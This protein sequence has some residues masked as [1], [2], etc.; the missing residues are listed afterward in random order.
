M[1]MVTVNGAPVDTDDPCALY[2][3]LFAVKLK[4]LAGEQVSEFSIQSPV[5]RET[6]IFSAA[7]REALDRELT[8]L[9]AACQQKTT[10]CRPSRRWNFRY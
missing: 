2:H 9:A 8:W 1:T 5:T 4:M 10:G 7:N 6:V 3:A